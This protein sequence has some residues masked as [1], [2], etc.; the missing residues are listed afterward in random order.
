MAGALATDPLCAPPLLCLDLQNVLVSLLT[1]LLQLLEIHLFLL[2]RESLWN[3]KITGW[4]QPAC[5]RTRM[6]RNVMILNAG[7]MISTGKAESWL[8]Q[9]ATSMTA[10][11]IST[12][13]EA[14][15]TW[16]H[17]CYWGHTN[18]YKG[19]NFHLGLFFSNKFHSMV[20]M[21]T[22]AKIYLSIV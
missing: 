6:A 10:M 22:S 7:S 2:M 1:C 16:N 21:P 8:D 3:W 15:L 19:S 17:V 11:M 4:E 12:T 9:N 18:E 20:P 13:D 5:T 14:V